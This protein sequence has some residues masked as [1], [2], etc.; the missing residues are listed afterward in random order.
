MGMIWKWLPVKLVHITDLY[1]YALQQEENKTH[2]SWHL[3][4]S[5]EKIFLQRSIYKSASNP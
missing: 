4:M 2:N 5:Y 1:F 3:Q